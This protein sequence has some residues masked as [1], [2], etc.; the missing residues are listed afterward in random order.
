MSASHAQGGEESGSR[1]RNEV[2]RASETCCATS[3]LM[4]VGV[5]RVTCGWRA[6]VVS[7]SLHVLSRPHNVCGNS[8]AQRPSDYCD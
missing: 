2:G 5:G 6:P 7:R 3:K 4:V 1:V 8:D